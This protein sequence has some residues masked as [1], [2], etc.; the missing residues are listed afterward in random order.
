MVLRQKSK[1]EIR[2]VIE[3]LRDI[4]VSTSRDAAFRTHFDR[5]LACDEQGEPL[6]KP[7]T[8]T[9]TG[10]TRGIALIDGAG[11]GKTS[12]VDRALRRHPAFMGSARDTKPVICASVP[13]PATLKSI[14]LEII[15]Q[16]GYPPPSSKTLAWE[17]WSL[18]RTRLL[19]CGT[20]VLWID[21][22]HDLFRRQSKSE[23]QDILRM[24]KS[25]M[26]GEGAVIVI[27]T[28]IET[29]WQI[30]SCDDQVKR[31]FSKI[32]LPPLSNAKD[33]KALATQIAIFC[34]HADLA[35]PDHPELVQRLIYASRERFGRCIENSISAIEVA[36]M[37]DA[38]QLESQHFAEAWAMQEGCAPGANVFLSPYWSQIDLAA[39]IAA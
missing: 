30:A 7:V 36:L 22:A 19:V 35:P 3:D 2:N 8:F 4:Y 6:P 20:V 39:R 15:R 5:L 32:E 23:V 34:G 28:G 26:Q 25:L 27:L 37:N 11:G 31:R 33:G 38:V 9:K 29:L 14:A 10:E 1:F 21:E 13:S 17:L 16:T 24:L 18:V 12:L